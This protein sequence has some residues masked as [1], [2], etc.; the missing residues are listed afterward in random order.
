MLT[1]EE[2]NKK[3]WKEIFDSGKIYFKVSAI[4][5]L[6]E[7]IKVELSSYND[8]D[9][10]IHIFDD[11]E[12]LLNKFFKVKE[13]YEISTPSEKD[14]LAKILHGQ[15]IAYQ[16][17]NDEGRC[18]FYL[19]QDQFIDLINYLISLEGDDDFYDDQNKYSLL[20]SLLWT[21]GVEVL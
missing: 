16:N 13:Y 21:L 18:F 9:E 12:E 19:N 6:N 14:G 11:L 15:G 4:E 5:L 1:N 17:M 20:C 7:K 3:K 10:D 2:K 8:F